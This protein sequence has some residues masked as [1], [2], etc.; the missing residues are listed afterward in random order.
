MDKTC[1]RES[2][3]F[4]RRFNLICK[5]DRGKVVGKRENEKEREKL[6]LK[7]NK[8]REKK[9]K[10]EM[11]SVKCELVITRERHARGQTPTPFPSSPPTSSFSLSSLWEWEVATIFMSY[12]IGILTK[13]SKSIQIYFSYKLCLIL[14]W[15]L[16][17]NRL[18]ILYGV[19]N[20]RLIEV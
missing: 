5:E 3:E 17:L 11:S 2:G 8:E 12:F 1:K 14:F 20:L 19:S 7:R 18:I 10:K 6:L 13:I 15:Q 9:K 16:F 4:Y